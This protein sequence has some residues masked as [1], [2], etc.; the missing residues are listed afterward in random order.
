M[1]DVCGE[2]IAGL[3]YVKA[4]DVVLEILK[5]NNALLKHTTFTHSYP[6]D[7]RTGKP[8]IFRA[9]DQWFCSIEPLISCSKD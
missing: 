2:R 6:H 5:E 9:T 7:W 4:N 3:F 8:L 1:M